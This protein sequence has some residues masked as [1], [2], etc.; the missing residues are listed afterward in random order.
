MDKFELVSDY[1]PMGD[2]PTAIKELV[3]GLKDHKNIRFCWGQQELVRPLQSQ[4][5]LPR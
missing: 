3:Q 2:Q 4:M 5:S 1:K